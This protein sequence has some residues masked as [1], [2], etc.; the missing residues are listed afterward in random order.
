MSPHLQFKLTFYWIASCVKRN[1]FPG[2]QQ[3]S[4]SRFL[5][6]NLPTELNFHITLFFSPAGYELRARQFLFDT[7]SVKS[8]RSHVVVSV[9]LDVW[10]QLFYRLRADGQLDALAETLIWLIFNAGP[11]KN[12]SELKVVNL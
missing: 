4:S 12:K 6:F 10:P 11:E 3:S 9:F 8:N 5:V 1:S 7:L 2:K